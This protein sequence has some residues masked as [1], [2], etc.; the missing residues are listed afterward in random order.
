M[1]LVDAIDVALTGI[2]GEVTGA[3]RARDTI[4]IVYIYVS[5]IVISYNNEK[6]IIPMKIDTRYPLRFIL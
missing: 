4:R 1:N 3:L 6:T 5:N 2:G